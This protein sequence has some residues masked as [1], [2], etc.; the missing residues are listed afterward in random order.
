MRARRW[1]G[2]LLAVLLGVSA[3]A[4]ACDSYAPGGGQSGGDA[5][6]GKSGY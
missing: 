5:T 1:W 2:V 3:V 4:Q 6:Q